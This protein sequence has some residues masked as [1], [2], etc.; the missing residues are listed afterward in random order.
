VE[1]AAIETLRGRTWLAQS[2]AAVGLSFLPLL[3]LT[4]P[5]HAQSPAELQPFT[6]DANKAARVLDRADHALMQTLRGKAPELGMD[7]DHVRAV[8]DLIGGWRRYTV[9]KCSLVGS[10][11][12]GVLAAR[13]EYALMCQERRYAARAVVVQ[14]V[15]S[16]LSHWLR[17]K[18]KGEYALQC[19]EPLTPLSSKTDYEA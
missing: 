15:T 18:P 7:E 8:E 3:V 11:T 4:Q 16:C 19:I 17:R 14:R 6:D 9:L 13:A 2:G 12:G 5:C 10:A 1:E